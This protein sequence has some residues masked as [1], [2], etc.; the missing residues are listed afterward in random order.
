MIFALAAVPAFAAGTPHTSYGMVDGAEADTSCAWTIYVVSRPGETL[1]GN[2]E[3]SSGIFYWMVN[4]GNLAT[5]WNLGEDSMVI[6]KKENNAGTTNHAGLYAAMNEDLSN[7]MPQAYNNC[8]MRYI[9]VPAAVVAGSVVDVNWSAAQTDTSQTPHGSNVSGYNVYRS[10]DGISFVKI[11]SGIVSGITYTDNDTNSNPVPVPD[12][13]YYY[14]IEP[15]FRGNVPLGF[16][17]ANS[18]QVTYPTPAQ[19]PENDILLNLTPN[20][21]NIFWIAVPYLHNFNAASD[22]IAKINTDHGIAADSGDV[23]SQI[24]R[25][26][27]ATQAYET[28]DFLGFLGWSGIDFPLPTG[29]SIFL[30]IVD[31]VNATLPGTHDPNF[32]FNLTHDPNQGNIF[33]ISLPKSGAYTDVV[34]IIADINTN[35]GLPADAGDV[36]SQVGH[37]DSATQAYE[38]YDHLGFLGWSGINFNFV[39]EEGYFINLVDSVNTWTPSTN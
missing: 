14:A 6:T 35:A 30:N 37:W 10:E 16:Y 8:T 36:V 4:I 21:G 9:P 13:P 29:E 3:E 32:A 11:N 31:N 17:S 15:I 25:W 12:T 23:I 2:L 7:E 39:T 38:T 28:Y 5:P 18:N 34:S 22:V 33:W 24:G 26:D 19:P 27:P 20:Q 1:T